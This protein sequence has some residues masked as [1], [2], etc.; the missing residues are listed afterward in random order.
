MRDRARALAIKVP[1]V[2]IWFW[3][4]KVLCTTVGETAADYLN[5]NLHL[6]LTGTSVVTAVLLAGALGLQLAAKRYVPWRYWLTVTLV[7]VFGT[8]VTDNLTDDFKVPLITSTI[9]FSVA[10]AVVF[11]AWYASEKTLSIHSVRTRRRESFYWLALFATFALGTATGDLM[12]ERLGFGY[13]PTGVMIAV[14]ISAAAV[15]RRFKL[16]S[17]LA[18]WIAYILT[19]PLGASIG[20]YLSQPRNAGG[21]GLGTT[22]TSFLFLGAIAAVVAFLSFTRADVIADHAD[23]DEPIERGALWQTAVVLTLV[24]VASVVGYNARKNTLTS[25]APSAVA[26][27]TKLGDLSTFRTITQDTLD[28]LTNG[29]QSGATKRVD[30]LETQWD[31]AQARLKARDT[32]TWTVIDA[33]IDTV[34]TRLRSGSPD[35]AKETTALNDLLAVLH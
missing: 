21:R 4:I 19:R 34:L 27:A 3:I 7:S 10:L 20:D 28:R 26:G 17:I 25:E 9:V 14:L 1:A 12:A 13:L 2:T 6:G 23:T 8:L 18:F 33:K 30:D 15:L 5:V 31:V 22:A 11:G 16:N 35:P 29:D 32:T 24:I